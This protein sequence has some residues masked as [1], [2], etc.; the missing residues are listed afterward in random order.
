M[1]W[2]IQQK[3]FFPRLVLIELSID[4]LSDF[5]LEVYSDFYPSLFDLTNGLL[6]CCWI[7]SHQT[8]LGFN[9]FEFLSNSLN[10]FLRWLRS[11]EFSKC[12]SRWSIWSWIFFICWNFTLRIFCSVRLPRTSQGFKLDSSKLL[13]IRKSLNQALKVPEK[14]PFGVL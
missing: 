13:L 4:F 6:P 3:I 8:Q 9:F 1:K 10:D 12:C 14:V 5:L 11:A 2:V 7:S